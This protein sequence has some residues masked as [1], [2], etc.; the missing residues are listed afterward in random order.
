M[1]Q[2]FASET[3]RVR[4]IVSLLAEALGVSHPDRYQAAS[5]LGDT[6]AIVEQTQ[7][8]WSKWGMTRERAF[9]TARGMF[10]PA[11]RT[12]ESVCACGKAPGERC[13]D[14]GEHVISVD[15]LSGVQ[16]H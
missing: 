15:V 16:A 13:G 7:P 9:Q 14:G 12:T 2:P 8:I 4:H 11:Y 5:Q 10:D 1:W 6:D 3:V